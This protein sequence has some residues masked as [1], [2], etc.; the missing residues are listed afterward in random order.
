MVY[1][2]CLFY[3]YLHHPSSVDE[4]VSLFSAP[5]CAEPSR[6]LYPH[7]PLSNFPNPHLHPQSHQQLHTLVSLFPTYPL[8]PI[9]FQPP[10]FKHPKS[11]FPYVEAS[12]TTCSRHHYPLPRSVLLHWSSSRLPYPHSHI[13][14]SPQTCTQGSLGLYTSHTPSTLHQ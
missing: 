12:T 2:A 1:S 9:H 7:P 11:P 4:C 6:G 10:L 14:K 13:C 8:P 5:T 3:A